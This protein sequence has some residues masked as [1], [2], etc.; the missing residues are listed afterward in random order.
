MEVRLDFWHQKTRV[1]GRPYGIVSLIL[2]LAIL[3]QYR[4]TT[5]G[6]THDDSIHCASIASHGKNYMKP[7]IYISHMKFII[8][9]I[10]PKI[11]EFLQQWNL[12]FIA[13]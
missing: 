1:S 11:L 4:Q 13:L 10:S 3:I 2:Y 7:H 12:N 5:E 8:R 6:Q 9:Q